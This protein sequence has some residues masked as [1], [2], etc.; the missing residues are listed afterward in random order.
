M[1]FS[2]KTIRLG[3]L[4]L[5]SF[6]AAAAPIGSRSKR[7]DYKQLGLRPGRRG[8]DTTGEYTRR[9][10]RERARRRARRRLAQEKEQARSQADTTK[11]ESSSSRQTRQLGPGHHCDLRETL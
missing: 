9:L 11:K 3:F 1:V 10:I 8:E 5:L 2:Y 4:L 7:I 6:T